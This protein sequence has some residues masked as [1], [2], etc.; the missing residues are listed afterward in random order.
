M[1]VALSYGA[2]EISELVERAKN[3]ANKIKVN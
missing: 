1:G 2:E 3:V